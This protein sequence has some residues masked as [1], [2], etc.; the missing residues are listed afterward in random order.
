[1]K[2]S[3]Q[4]SEYNRQYHLK[5]K[6]KIINHYSK[7]TMTCCCDGCTENQIEF[8]TIDHEDDNGAEHRRIIGIGGHNTLLWL[9]RNNYPIGY[10]VL[11]W[12][13]NSARSIGTNANGICPHEKFIS[14]ILY[15]S[16]DV[17]G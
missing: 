15:K 2:C 1:M 12:N 7:G 10:R 3:Q 14:R 16:E 13:C 6:E 5:I 4:K 17:R 11:C 8:L 9:I